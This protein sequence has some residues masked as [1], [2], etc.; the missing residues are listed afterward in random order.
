MVLISTPWVKSGFYYDVWESDSS[1]WYRIKV[2]ADQIPRITPEFLEQEKKLMPKEVYEREYFN[3]FMEL[4]AECCFDMDLLKKC[5]VP[6][7]EII[8]I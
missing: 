7:I 5:I 1:E 3:K 6:G 4:S 8:A 2:S